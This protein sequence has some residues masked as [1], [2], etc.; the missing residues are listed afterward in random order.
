VTGASRFLIRL[1]TRFAARDGV[2][3]VT[4]AV[5]G[6]IVFDAGLTENEP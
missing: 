4:R 2:P 5:S 1:V 3:A 6:T